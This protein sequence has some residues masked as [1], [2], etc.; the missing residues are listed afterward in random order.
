MTE[1]GEENILCSDDIALLEPYT[2]TLCQPGKGLREIFTQ[3]CGSFYG[4]SANYVEQ[5][6]D[7]IKCLHTAS[8]IID[9]I[10]DHSEVRRGV[11]ASHVVYG[12]PM[13]I[14]AS[15]L[16]IFKML[17]S[18][19]H[20]YDETIRHKVTDVFLKELA[21]LHRGQG[22]DILWL[23]RDYCPS[24]EEYENMVQLKTGSLFRL[25][26][27]LARSCSNTTQPNPVFEDIISK[28]GMY[29]QIRDD[30]I[31][32]ADPDYWEKK[33]F[34]ED[35]DEGKYSYPMILLKEEMGEQFP[36]L[37]V[38]KKK[39]SIEDKLMV[40]QLL[41]ANNILTRVHHELLQRAAT[42]AKHLAT[43]Q[44]QSNVDKQSPLKTLMYI[45]QNKLSA[46]HPLKPE[47]VYR[48]F[49]KCL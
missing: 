1:A 43:L 12:E 22:L 41:Y 2:Y 37:I 39:K 8:I 17:S 44:S 33:G 4:T 26:S 47:Q 14:N 32:I 20:R 15:Y 11:K 10:E 3:I 16:A 9:D 34:F 6:A 7:D 5:I 46:P 35:L 21:H 18:I 19:T 38:E 25:A 28:I 23:H 40:Y 49:Q 29:Y 48:I 36:S 42:I 27:H 45:V 31:N 13:S 30:Y 24:I